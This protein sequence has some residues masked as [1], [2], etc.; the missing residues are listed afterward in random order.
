MGSRMF[1]KFFFA[2]LWKESRDEWKCWRERGKSTALNNNNYVWC[3]DMASQCS[4]RDSMFWVRGGWG[5]EGGSCLPG[6]GTSAIYLPAV[7]GTHFWSQDWGR[8]VE[9]EISEWRDSS[10]PVT[11]PEFSSDKEDGFEDRLVGS[12]LGNRHSLEDKWFEAV[13]FVWKH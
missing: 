12:F 5:W 4:Y 10:V 1:R 11:L 13:F 9:M 8:K 3:L 2:Q 7:I 6:P